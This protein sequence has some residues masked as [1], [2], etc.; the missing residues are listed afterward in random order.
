[1]A[2]AYIFI[3]QSGAGKGTQVALLTKK[4]LA[5]NPEAVPFYVETGSHFRKLIEGETFTAVHTRE[6]I[7]EGKLP[8]AFLGAHMWAHELIEHYD[9]VQPVILDGTPRVTAEV[10]LLLST[11]GFYGWDAHVLYIAVGD[12][13]SY[14]KIVGRGRH[15]DTDAHAWGRIQWF[16]ESVEPSVD[17]LRESPLVTFHNIQGEQSIEDVHADIC[18]SLGI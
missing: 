2:T 4:L 1:M 17:M 11:I 12:E 7:G 3:G 13:W 5:A 8:P 18:R 9:G 10:P 16:H 15:D 14:D 6:M